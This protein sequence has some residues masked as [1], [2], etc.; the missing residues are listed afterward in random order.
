MDQPKRV[1]F[2]SF[3]IAGILV[4]STA[5]LFFGW[6]AEEM[7]EADT[8]QFDTF[9]RTTIHGLVSPRLTSAMQG[10]SFL[11]SV[12]FIVGLTVVT[13]ALFIYFHRPRAAVLLAATM[14]GAAVLDEVLKYAF[15]RSRPVAFFGTSPG[16]YSFPSGHALE[17]MCFYGVMAVILSERTPTRAGRM[18]IYAGTIL[19]VGAIG[20]SRIY[21]G[22]HYPSDVIAGYL[23]AIFW[24]GSVGL[25]HDYIR[26]RGANGPERLGSASK[27]S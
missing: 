15:H 6:L 16:S 18:L 21:L 22:V 14:T 4:A 10:I 25:S 2:G 8:A 5:L 19:L 3:L 27:P 24:V 23:A 1:K 17:S 11:G 26:R 13:L 20:I 12:A 9:V 7:L